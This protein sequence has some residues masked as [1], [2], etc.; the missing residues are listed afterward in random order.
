M[1]M[2]IE[3]AVATIDA[4]PR[5]SD[6][7]AH[8]A[9]AAAAA[10]AGS[11]V[12]AMPARHVGP[13]ATHPDASLA[14]ELAVVKQRIPEVEGQ[15]TQVAKQVEAAVSKRD[16]VADDEPKWTR[17]DA[18]VQRLGRKEEQ[19]RYEKQ[20]LRDELARKELAMGRAGESTYTHAYTNE[21]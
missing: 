4:H 5:G 21:A 7:A 16:S 20:Q 1:S 14:A 19:L 17:F 3:S 15:I 6:A 11:A 12:A 8:S 2:H 13:G 9:A 10:S 18:D